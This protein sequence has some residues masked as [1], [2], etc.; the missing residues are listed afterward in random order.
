MPFLSTK[1]QCGEKKKLIFAEIVKVN[2]HKVDYDIMEEPVFYSVILNTWGNNV[3]HSAPA[4]R[5]LAVITFHFYSMCLKVMWL[6][7]YEEQLLTKGAKNKTKL[8]C[9]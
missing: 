7:A 1:D 8:I 5:M 3:R 2:D 4:Q 6:L 9:S